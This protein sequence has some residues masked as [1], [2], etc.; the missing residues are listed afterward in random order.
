MET[1]PKIIEPIQQT[2][3]AILRGYL[4]NPAFDRKQVRNALRILSQ[5]LIG[6]ALKKIKSAYDKYLVDAK[7]AADPPAVTPS[8][9]SHKLWDHPSIRLRVPG[10]FGDQTIRSRYFR[11]SDY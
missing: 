8:S 10:T 7:G 4:N 3:S 5:P 11:G 1:A 6:S 9:T 2:T